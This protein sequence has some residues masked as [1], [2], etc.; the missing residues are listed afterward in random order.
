MKNT[1]C[2]IPFNNRICESEVG[3]FSHL[4]FVSVK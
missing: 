1:D 4:V 2:D 3:K